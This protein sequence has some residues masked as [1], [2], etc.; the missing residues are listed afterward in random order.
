MSYVSDAAIQRLRSV[1]SWPGFSDDRYQV[2]REIGRGGMGT[3]YLGRDAALNREVAIKVT[4]GAAAGS[5]LEG[6]MRMEARFVA[7][8]EHPGIVPI[9]DTGTL[10]DGRLFTVMKLVRG[11]TLGAHLASVRELA[12]RLL[13]FERICEPVAFAHARGMVHRDLKPGNIM[14]GAFGEVLVMD[15]GVAKRLGE[16][17]EAGEA[18]ER[19]SEGNE[20]RE[21]PSVPSNTDPG[22]VIGTAGYMAP[23]QALGRNDV[24]ARADVYALGAILFGMITGQE[25]HPQD[26]SPAGAALP[27]TV[28]KRLR[29][30]CAKAMASAAE[31]RYADAAAL[32]DDLARLRSGLPVSAYPESLLDHAARLALKYRTPILLILTYLAVRT[33]IAVVFGR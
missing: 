32:A 5:A 25:S 31:A 19:G 16:K 6:R 10:A 22:T 33:V 18:G 8:L 21:V 1:A 13:L 29:A 2:V 9:H 27:R 7:S 4:N 28:P 14:I 12:E 30:I 24:D 3:V 17:G 26:M 20:G 23:E 11:V 15:W